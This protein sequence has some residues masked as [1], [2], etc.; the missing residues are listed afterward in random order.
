[1]AMKR[2]ISIHYPR[3]VGLYRG[4]FH[5]K[6]SEVSL[7]FK[8]YFILVLILSSLKLK[9]ESVCDTK[10]DTTVTQISMGRIKS[11]RPTLYCDDDQVQFSLGDDVIR[12]KRAT[13]SYYVAFFA[14]LLSEY[15]HVIFRRRRR[16]GY[17]FC[18]H[19]NILS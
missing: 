6:F 10:D 14:C 1:M 11:S 19:C 9:K 2:A 17:R 5:H 18:F 8:R 15:T 13:S 4:C 16:R 12:S 7:F 3:T